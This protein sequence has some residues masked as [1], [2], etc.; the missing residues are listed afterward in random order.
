MYRLLYLTLV[1]SLVIGVSTVEARVNNAALEAI[2]LNE[3]SPI[4]FCAKK[5]LKHRLQTDKNFHKPY[6]RFLL[7]FD[8]D[9]FEGEVFRKSG[10]SHI[11]ITKNVTIIPQ[12]Y[13]MENLDILI[14]RLNISAAVPNNDYLSIVEKMLFGDVEPWGNSSPIYYNQDKSAVLL[15]FHLEGDFLGYAVFNDGWWGFPPCN[16]TDLYNEITYHID[17]DNRYNIITNEE[18]YFFNHLQGA[19]S[20]RLML[21]QNDVLLDTQTLKRYYYQPESYADISKFIIWEEEKLKFNLS[22]EEVE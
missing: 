13:I 4:A 8:P 5:V 17:N 14:E 7:R 18:L 3:M 11:L 6:W 9:R 10:V 2:M 20:S 19:P 22:F 12:T 21:L 1:L 15:G 16:T